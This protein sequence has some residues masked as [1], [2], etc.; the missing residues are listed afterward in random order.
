MIKFDAMLE[1]RAHEMHTIAAIAKQAESLGFAG[2]WAPETKHNPLFQLL[3]AAEHT[4]H[5]ELGT[6][7]IVA[8]PRSPMT[9]AQ[10]AWDL[11]AFSEGR[12]LLGLGT[13]VKAHIERRFSTAWEHPV[14]KLRDYILALRAI[15]NSFQTGKR[16]YYQGEFYKFSLMTPFFNPGPIAHPHIPIYIAGVN[17]GLAQLAGELCD[18]FHVHPAHTVKYVQEF[19]KPQ[20]AIGA[21][22]S[23][24]NLA[25]IALASGCFVITGKDAAQMDK[26]REWVRQQL[27]FYLSTPSYRIVLDLHGWHAVGEQLSVLAARQQWA[28]MPQLISDDML[29]EFA[30]EA[31]PERLGSVLRARYA[32]VLDRVSSYIPYLP[33]EMDDV[34]REVIAQ[35]NTAA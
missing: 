10:A 20:I 2:L 34:W 13:Q 27:S 7:I 9:M 1:V 24:R 25:D 33:N 17:E 26:T 14:A 22:K 21:A 19:V 5:I 35:L 8:F 12:F 30:V 3:L 31:P 23:E 6:A 16:L 4:N 32:G 15:W 28:D 11:Q 18:G 29:H